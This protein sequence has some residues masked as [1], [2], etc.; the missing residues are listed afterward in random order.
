M[1]TETAPIIRTTRHRG[2]AFDFFRRHTGQCGALLEDPAGRGRQWVIARAGSHH[3]LDARDPTQLDAW[4]THLTPR[5][6]LPG[7]AIFALLYVGYEAGGLFEQ[8]PAAKTATPF[9]L[10]Y[11]HFPAWSL[12]FHGDD[13]LTIGAR[14]H[15]ALEQVTDLLRQG[16]AATP[17]DDA[18]PF[19]IGEVE[20]KQSPEAYC[21]A[22][23]QVQEEIRRGEI[24]QANIARFW[25]A[26]LRRGDDLALYTRLRTRNPAPFSCIVRIEGSGSIV[27]ASPERL[28]RIRDDGTIDTR[29]IAGTRR[30]GDGAERERLR[31]ELLLSDKERAE[32]VMLVDLER[33]DLG[34]LCEPGSIE[35]D[36]SMVVERYAT[37]QH[38]VSNVRGRLRPGIDLIDVLASMFPGGTITGCP[39]IRCME[40]IHAIEPGPRGPYTGSVGYLTWD[41]SADFNILI[42]TFWTTET[43]KTT[44]LHWAAGAGIVSDSV[45]E[46]ER[47]ETEHKAAGLLA[48]L[49][50]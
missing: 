27:S 17:A 15:A 33:N 2:S 48:A 25:H 38:I 47:E 40:I 20:E 49:E 45:P 44:M 8:L 32:H 31:R 36:E 3:R 29:P 35:V 34:R 39:K 4:R 22:V 24:F 46:R 7:P 28:F 6:S 30:L 23:R 12:C 10:L 41:G 14:S 19:A 9:P 13:T 18:H 26:P 37:V 5:H 11:A 50:G 43:G 1:D 42:R 21:R 16:D